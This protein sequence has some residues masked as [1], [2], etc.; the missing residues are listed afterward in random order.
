MHSEG[1]RVY[2]GTIL[3]GFP[4]FVRSVGGAVIEA[5]V[6]PLGKL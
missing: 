1:K 6:V 4:F 3:S 5:P 2:N